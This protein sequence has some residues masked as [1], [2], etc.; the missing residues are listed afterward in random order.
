MIRAL[1]G[2]GTVYNSLREG[3]TNDLRGARVTADRVA[4]AASGNAATAVQGG[5]QGDQG[6][7]NINLE[8]ELAKMADTTIR[9]DAETRL[10]REAY[11]RLRT[12]IGSRG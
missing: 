2:T 7:N 6:Q 11:T 10:L 12:A 8:E 3:L 4:N 1:F 5:L 9:Y